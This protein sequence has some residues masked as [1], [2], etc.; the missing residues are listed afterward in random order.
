MT[1][2]DQECQPVQPKVQY[3]YITEK[4]ASQMSASVLISKLRT[5]NVFFKAEK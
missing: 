1:V 2:K 5:N 4:Y 3:D